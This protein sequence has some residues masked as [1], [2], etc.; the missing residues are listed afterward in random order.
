MIE[1]FGPHAEELRFGI[2]GMLLASAFG[3][4]K[5]GRMTAYDFTVSQR[6]LPSGKPQPGLADAIMSALGKLAV[7]KDEWQKK[8]KRSKKVR[9]A[10]K[11]RMKRERR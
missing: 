1:P 11:E 9:Q 8:G 7:T 3:G 5:A 4:K 6:P 10:M 2:L